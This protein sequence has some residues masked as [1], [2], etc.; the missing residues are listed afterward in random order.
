MLLLYSLKLM[1][2]HLDLLINIFYI[3]CVK[4][5]KTLELAQ[6]SASQ[7]VRCEDLMSLIV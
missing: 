6:D 5:K 1:S 7:N 4:R 2:L 3:L